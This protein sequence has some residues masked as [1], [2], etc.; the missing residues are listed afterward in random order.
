MGCGRKPASE[1]ACGYGMASPSLVGKGAGEVG[2]GFRPGS[3]SEEGWR[4][5]S[6]WRGLDDSGHGTGALARAERIGSKSVNLVLLEFR[7]FLGGR[8][9]NHATRGMDL[10]GHLEALLPRVAEQLLQ[11]G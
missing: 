4:G 8:Q 9:D 7:V 10:Q 11:H 6:A 2:F 5:L 3:E 1:A